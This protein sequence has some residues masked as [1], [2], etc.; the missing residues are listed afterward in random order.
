[1]GKWL[2]KPKSNSELNGV[3]TELL[4]AQDSIYVMDSHQIALWCWGQDPDFGSTNF[5]HIDAHYDCRGI[6]EDPNHPYWLKDIPQ[7]PHDYLARTIDV[8][9]MTLPQMVWDNIVSTYLLHFHQGG[10][11]CL[12]TPDSWGD[13]PSPEVVEFWPLYQLN[14]QIHQ[15]MKS[16]EKWIVDV[17]L[18]YFLKRPDSGSYVEWAEEE[19]IEVARSLKEKRDE[20]VIA[21]L[22]IAMSACCCGG[23]APS[24]RILSIFCDALDLDFP[25][26]TLAR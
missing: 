23:L 11:V 16:G 12:L 25:L 6:N 26:E 2:I 9:G 7:A 17:D 13:K 4:W 19:I 20:S 24:K 21:T 22:T 8:S 5:L 1:V 10:R 18:D 15:N 3:R 14:E